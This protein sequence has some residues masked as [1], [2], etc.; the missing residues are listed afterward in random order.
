M[1]KAL[2]I[3]KRTTL[4]V[5]NQPTDVMAALG[6]RGGGRGGGKQLIII[7][8][9]NSNLYYICM[10]SLLLYKVECV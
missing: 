6:D 1:T 8:T 3:P 4:S 2:P 9:N 5:D 10:Y 7:G